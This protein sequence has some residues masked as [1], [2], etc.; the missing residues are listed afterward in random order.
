MAKTTN[1]DK[2]VPLEVVESTE[3]TI[4]EVDEANLVEALE[5]K[6]TKELEIVE[7][8]TDR[9]TT[10]DSITKTVPS[11]VITTPGQAHRELNAAER[12]RLRRRNLGY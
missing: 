5:A 6:A 2:D 4:R 8:Q 10:V 3:P 12:E 11:S 1:P 7:A 9:K